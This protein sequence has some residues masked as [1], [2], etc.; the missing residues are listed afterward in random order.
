MTG[1][2]KL[3]TEEITL[4]SLEMREDLRGINIWYMHAD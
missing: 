3:V 4:Y 2:L 1:P